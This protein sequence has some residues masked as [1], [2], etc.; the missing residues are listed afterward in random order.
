MV[1]LHSVGGGNQTIKVSLLWTDSQFVIAILN[2]QKKTIIWKFFFYNLTQLTE[3]IMTTSKF[4]ST[5]RK[6]SF[7]AI[8]VLG[9]VSSSWASAQ[10]ILGPY[11]GANVGQTKA[12]FSN[13]SINRRVTNQGLK[14]NSSNEDNRDT[15]YKVFGGYQFNRNI[16]LEGGYFDLGSFNYGLNT[17]PIGSFSGSTR[18]RG[19]NLDLV[20]TLPL[21]SQ[22]SV[23]GRVGAAYAQTKANFAS[24]GAV[25]PST[26]DTQRKDT[27]LKLGIG[28]QYA[29]TEALS[30]RAELERYRINDPV[31]NRGHVDMASLG[32]V[33]R[34]GPKAQ[35]PVAY[36]PIAA[37]PQPPAAV[38]V[39]P[40][41][42]YVA[43]PPPPAVMAP[44]PA[45]QPVYVAPTR[46]AKEGRN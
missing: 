23:F 25:A 4:P 34:F 17:T 10:D 31:R 22:F 45:P 18:V 13:D 33:Y 26:F 19:L 39:A 28:L 24:T 38:Y 16:A 12:D 7:L 14:I 15:G 41:P 43:P 35:T 1:L 9:A 36:V 8:A 20:G 6:L 21:S 40:A 27:N 2:Q 5:K 42:V 30:L 29:I 46:P 3:K 32:L 37:A 11:I 44:A